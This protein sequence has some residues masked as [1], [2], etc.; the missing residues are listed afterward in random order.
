MKRFLLFFFMLSILNA[1]VPGTNPTLPIIPTSMKAGI[2]TNTPQAIKWSVQEIMDIILASHPQSDKY[3]PN[4]TIY[5]EFPEALKQLKEMGPNVL[6]DD[7]LN[8][9]V[10]SSAIG[11]PRQDSILAGDVLITFPPEYVSTT[12]PELI[13]YLSN[14]RTEVRRYASILLGYVG[15]RASCAVGSIGPILFLAKDPSV[16]SAS[17]IALDNI[18]NKGFVPPKYAISSNFFSVSSIPNDEPEGSFTEKARIWW[19]EEGSKVNWHPTYD[20]CDP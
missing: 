19:N 8:L 18:L 5:A 14:P 12:M 13:G 15:D 17:A 3:D 9:S 11:Y 10:L 6:K 1:C 2:Q 20:L 16:R 4:S 7:N